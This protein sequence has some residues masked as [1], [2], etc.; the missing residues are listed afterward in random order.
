FVFDTVRAMSPCGRI[1]DYGCGSGDSVL[2]GA[3]SG[4]DI[5]GAD[6]FYGG[7]HG[8]MEK[9]ANTGVLNERVFEMRGGRIPFPDESFDFIYHTQ[10]FEHVADLDQ[11][12]NE[13]RR[14]LKRDGVMLSLF[15]SLE[16]LRE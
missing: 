14:V 4:L 7:A 8:D 11:A 16:V 5:Y 13:N 2:A 9:A 3:R 10:V 6:V 12:L 1:L 15:P